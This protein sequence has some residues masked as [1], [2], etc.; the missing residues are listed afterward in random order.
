MSERNR[1]K[2]EASDAQTAWA[3]LIAALFL[4][5]AI[6]MAQTDCAEGNGLLDSATPKE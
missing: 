5:S 2:P 1:R 6:A 4:F 3:A